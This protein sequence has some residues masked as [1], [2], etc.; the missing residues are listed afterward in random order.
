MNNSTVP[1][2]KMLQGF[3]PTIAFVDNSAPAYWIYDSSLQTPTGGFLFGLYEQMALYGGFKWNYTLTPR[4]GS[5]SDDDY[6]LSMCTKYD[7]VA[8]TSFDTLARRS[9]GLSFSP[10]LLEA[11]LVLI[12]DSSVYESNHIPILNSWLYPFSPDLWGAIIAAICGHALLQW[13][14]D[15]TEKICKNIKV[16]YYKALRMQTELK[17]TLS[18][19]YKK[20]TN[21]LGNEEVKTAIERGNED[22]EIKNE[23]EQGK[24]H[25]EVVSANEQGEEKEEVFQ[26]HGKRKIKVNKTPTFDNYLYL[27]FS[28]FANTDGHSPENRPGKALYLVFGFFLLICTSSYTANLASV[29]ISVGK[30]TLPIQSIAQAN[31]LGAKVCFR[32]GAAA[33]SLT[34]SVYKNI[35]VVQTATPDNNQVLQMLQE[36][37]CQAAVLA[38]NDWQVAGQL[39]ANNAACNLQIV[40]PVVRHLNA[41]LPFLADFNQECSS[42]FGN[43]FSA[44]LTDLSQNYIVDQLWSSTL[45]TYQEVDCSAVPFSSSSSVSSGLSLFQMSGLFVYFASWCGLILLWHIIQQLL[46][47]T[48]VAPVQDNSV[49][50]CKCHSIQQLFKDQNSAQVKEKSVSQCNESLVPANSLYY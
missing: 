5:A 36:G 7:T 4:Q 10:P 23:I 8:K 34:T 32:K 2:T 22:L 18:Q 12:I 44:L 3:R 31:N 49:S 24:E 43:V 46:K 50:H 45:H 6:L 27:S 11:S 14:I 29:L 20:T 42:Y 41:Y 9:K 30:P 1:V 16:Y 13:L 48:N 26:R 37:K 40:G 28:A 15:K 33:I 39:I 47:D 35:Q 19:R 17:K 21:E 25:P 38:Y